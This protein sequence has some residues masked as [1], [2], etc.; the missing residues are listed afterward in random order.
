MPVEYPL[1]EGLD[2]TGFANV[3]DS[4][5]LQMIRQ[6]LPGANFGVVLYGT[7][8]PDVGNNPWMARC[9]WLDSNDD[10][11]S[12]RF[13][14]ASSPAWELLKV[15]DGSITNAKIAIGAIDID[16][17][18]IDVSG[19]TAGQILAL[20]SGGTLLEWVTLVSHITANTLPIAKLVKGGT[21]TFLKTDSGDN[22]AWAALLASEIPSGISEAKLSPGSER[23]VLQTLSGAPVW[24]DPASLMTLAELQS[25]IDGG[26]DHTDLDDL[27]NNNIIKG[28]GSGNVLVPLPTGVSVKTVTNTDLSTLLDGAAPTNYEPIPHTQT[29]TP[30]VV[31]IYFECINALTATGHIVGDLVSI[32]KAET[33][34]HVNALD[35]FFDGT[36]VNV[37][38]HTG[39]ECSIPHKSAGTF[40]N[41]AS[42]SEPTY[43]RLSVRTIKA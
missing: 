17:N 6:A 35:F 7:T 41:I 43:W 28:T 24:I 23:D 36:N 11:P 34:A 31:Q 13:Y 22:V 20:N 9:V 27:G 1:V 38:S 25:I 33:T 37:V 21:S 8:T 30:E 42:G 5:L 4:Q 10:P 15:P 12:P 2:I 3:T 26:L 14:N 19:G 29:G 39:T 16:S 18:K 40:H 32:H